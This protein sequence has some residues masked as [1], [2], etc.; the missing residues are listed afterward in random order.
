PR[1]EIFSIGGQSEPA[2]AEAL[3]GESN[4][5]I[6]IAVAGSD[7]VAEACNKEI[8]DCDVAGRTADRL[9][10]RRDVDH[11]LGWFAVGDAGL[12]RCAAFRAHRAKASLAFRA[13]TPGAGRPR[14]KDAGEPSFDAVV[15]RVEIV[16][17][18][19]VAHALIRNLADTVKAQPPYHVARPSPAIGCGCERLL[20]LQH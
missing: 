19:S 11:H 6:R 16:F 12:H 7:R 1:T 15:S 8:T 5:A 9:T 13:E 2:E 17:A 18:H 4:R 3:I 14:R 20:G 10:R